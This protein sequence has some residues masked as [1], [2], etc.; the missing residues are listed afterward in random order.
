MFFS[1]AISH[2]EELKVLD[3]QSQCPHNDCEHKGAYFLGTYYLA[4]SS[5]TKAVDCY[6]CADRSCGHQWT[7]A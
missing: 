5:S 6:E 1:T 7:N 4:L 3:K 2:S